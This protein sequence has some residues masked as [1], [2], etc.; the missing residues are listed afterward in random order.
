MNSILSPRFALL[1]NE[2]D[3]LK[4]EELAIKSSLLMTTLIFPLSVVLLIW[5]QWVLALFGKDFVNAA[6]LLRIMCIGQ[7]IN[8]VSG[9]V[10]YIL[11]MTGHEHEM[12]KI[13]FMTLLVSVI[14]NIIL[15]GLYGA[16]GAAITI[17]FCLILQNALMTMAVYKK[18]GIFILP[19]IKNIK[20]L[21]TYYPKL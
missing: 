7:I 10:G 20:T 4:I 17:T 6:L 14:M 12:K 11:M 19:R 3:I 5:P 13:M 21:L 8:V 18:L 9:S 2:K 1:Y 16:V 15:I